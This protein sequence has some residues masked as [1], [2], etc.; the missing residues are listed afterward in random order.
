MLQL[1]LYKDPSSIYSGVNVCLLGTKNNHSL[2]ERLQPVPIL[3]KGV[4]HTHVFDAP[5]IGEIQA[6]MIAPEN[7]SLAVEKID[8]Y[9]N[10]VLSRRFMLHEEIGG[11]GK[12][13]AAL[14]KPSLVLTPELK[15]QYD[16]DYIELKNKINFG[17]LHLSIIGSIV[18]GCALGLQKAL[19]FSIG[20]FLAM[21]YVQLLQYEVDRLGTKNSAIVMNATIRLAILFSVATGLVARH[22]DEIV[23]DN[24]EF[25]IGLL[26]F[27]MYKISL[28][29]FINNKQ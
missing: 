21:V 19:V 20:G 15:H 17:T 23:Q 12:D 16:L 1:Q 4:T 29:Q 14:I 3:Q 26:G 22:H 11:R 8:V 24:S 13:G 27:V 25:I 6:L 2:L 28:M 10:D 9:V 5:D 18:T 7:G